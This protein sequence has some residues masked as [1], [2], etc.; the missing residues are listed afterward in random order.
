VEKYEYPED[1]IRELIANAII[2]RD[3]KIIETYNQIRIFKDRIEIVNPGSLPP[4]VTVENIKEAQF[5]RNSMIAAR[6]KDLRYLEEYGRGINIVIKKMWEWNLPSPLFRNAG[7][8][9][10]AILLGE[11]YRNLNDRQVKLIDVLL[12]K[13]RLTVQDCRKILRGIPRATINSD[14]KKL[15]DCG[16]F[17]TKGASVNTYYELA[18]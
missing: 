11:R 14:L 8:S 2:H 6:L 1:G 12:L 13:S 4:G 18:F 9:F 15:R 7:N 10:E 5:S 3:Y 16:I 17:I